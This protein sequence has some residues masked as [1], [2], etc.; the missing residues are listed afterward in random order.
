[1][2][3]SRKVLCVSSLIVAGLLSVFLS[4][5]GAFGLV[6]GGF[7][8]D[9]ESALLLGIFLPL[10]FTFPLFALSVGVSKLASRALWV[11]VPFPWLAWF[12][13]SLHGFKGGPLDLA[14][15]LAECSYMAW[16]LLFLA[17]LV[18]F[19]THFYEF[20]HDSRWVRW[21]EAKHELGA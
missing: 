10:L 1:M 5:L 14:K 19:G 2:T 11:C 18:Q 7:P 8:K 15:S 9:G 13:T 21:K 17:A 6:W 16:P 12:E 4:F 20:T 3:T